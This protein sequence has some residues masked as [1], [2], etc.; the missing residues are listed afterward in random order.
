MT[1]PLYLSAAV[2]IYCIGV[3]SVSAC[4]SVSDAIT[5]MGGYVTPAFAVA[6]QARKRERCFQ[7]HRRGGLNL[8]QRGSACASR[9]LPRDASSE[10]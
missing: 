5:R 6:L 1:R 2:S 8:R 9:G 3:R 4:V 7:L 10:V